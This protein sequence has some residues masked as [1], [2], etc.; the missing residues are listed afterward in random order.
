MREIVSIHLGQGGTQTS[1]ACW[2]LYRLEDGI[3][4]NG[5]MPRSNHWQWQRNPSFLR[6]HSHESFVAGIST[7]YTIRE[8]KVVADFAEDFYMTHAANV[9]ELLQAWNKLCA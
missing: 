5:T 7:M 9:D 6:A 3:Q 1:N 4:S 8:R 2:S